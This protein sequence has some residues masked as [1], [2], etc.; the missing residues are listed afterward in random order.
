MFSSI[1]VDEAYQALTAHPLTRYLCNPELIKEIDRG[2][3]GPRDHVQLDV[4]MDAC[5]HCGICAV[6]CATDGFARV[7]FGNVVRKLHHYEC[8]RD[9][10]CERSCPTRAIRLRNL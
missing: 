7:P 5:I 1:L 2:I 3:D 6:T 10:A 9:A 4:D 8:T